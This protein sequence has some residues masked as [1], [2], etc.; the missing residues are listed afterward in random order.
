[1]VKVAAIPDEVIEQYSAKCDSEGDDAARSV[2]EL[3]KFTRSVAAGNEGSGQDDEG[4][5]QEAARPSVLLSLKYKCVDGEDIKLKILDNGEV[6]GNCSSA[7]LA[8]IV[9]ILSTISI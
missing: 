3:L 7:Q 9:H 2:E 5:G 8:S 4:S 1:M 6:S